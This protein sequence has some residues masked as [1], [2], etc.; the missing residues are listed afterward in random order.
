MKYDMNSPPSSNINEIPNSSN[1]NPIRKKVISL[2]DKPPAMLVV[3]HESIVKELAI[4]D[5][6]WL[7]EILS[8]D[9][10]LLKVSSKKIELSDDERRRGQENSLAREGSETS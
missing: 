9:G 2:G 6:T 3:L 8:N 1:K 7:E 5:N 4:D 10:I